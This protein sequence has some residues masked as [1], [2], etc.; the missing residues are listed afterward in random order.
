MLVVDRRASVPSLYVD[1]QF[2]SGRL[3]PL[4]SGVLTGSS[5]D[6]P[7]AYQT[8]NTIVN[9]LFLYICVVCFVIQIGKEASDV[10]RVYRLKYV[11]HALM[12]CRFCF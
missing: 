3:D 2:G 9:V 8:A 1:F 6:L 10:S 11:K 7:E 12:K 5:P 4:R